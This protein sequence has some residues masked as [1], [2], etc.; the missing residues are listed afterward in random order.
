MLKV[1]LTTLAISITLPATAATRIKNGSFDSGNTGFTTGLKY[2][3]PGKNTLNS[4]NTFSIGKDVSLFSTAFRKITD[5]PY[6]HDRGMGNYMVVNGSTKANSVVWRQSNIPFVS[7]NEY[8]F[9]NWFAS[10]SNVNRPTFA[11]YYNL[12]DGQGDQFLGQWRAEN[13]VGIWQG[14][15]ARFFPTGRNLTITIYDLVGANAGNNFVLDEVRLLTPAEW[16]A[17]HR[18]SAR[19]AFETSTAPEPTS[20]A[21]MVI[22]F[23]L[24]GV[25]R[26]RRAGSVTA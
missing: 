20:W 10:L 6:G 26:R 22:G 14:M 15:E 3:A 11:V 1:L 25:A 9:D 13:D 4:S 21:M 12:S 18:S 17:G 23:G 2:V 7:G 16:S 19:M 24:V 8:V 5:L